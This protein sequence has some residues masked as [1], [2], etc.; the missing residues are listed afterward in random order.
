[1]STAFPTSEAGYQVRRPTENV[2]P[3]R[4]GGEPRSAF[5]QAREEMLENTGSTDF[6]SGFRATLKCIFTWGDAS[7]AFIILIR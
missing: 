4:V 7:G 2:A 3:D 1:M 5:V 6:S